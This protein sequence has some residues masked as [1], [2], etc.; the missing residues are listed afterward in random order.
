MRNNAERIAAK[1]RKMRKNI[2]IMK[3]K[4]L[5]KIL[6]FTALIMGAL[7][8]QSQTHAQDTP[9][10]GGYGEISVRSA[11]AQSSAKFAVSARARRTRKRIVLWKVVKA[12]QQVVAGMNYRVCMRVFV[13]GKARTV[14]AVVYKNLRQKRSLTSWQPGGCS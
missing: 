9:I 2:T 11:E 4:N 3:M 1:R 10:V 12:E 14:T 7:A 8:I 5:S 6:I 13:G